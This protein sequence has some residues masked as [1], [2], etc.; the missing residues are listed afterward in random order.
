V[1]RNIELILNVI[2]DC[3]LLLYKKFILILIKR[4]VITTIILPLKYYCLIY[5]RSEIT[6]YLIKYVYLILCNLHLT[7]I[8]L[9]S[10]FDIYFVIRN[11]AS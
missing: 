4:F 9:I 10:I 7:N 3:H 11:I 6:F 5:K 1:I 2:T 8:I